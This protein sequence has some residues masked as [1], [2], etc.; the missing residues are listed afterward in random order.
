[1][2]IMI[3]ILYFNI[4]SLGIIS[5]KILNHKYFRVFRIH[6]ILIVFTIVQPILEFRRE[7]LGLV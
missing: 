6:I 4:I 3:S 5:I 7:E 1:M 2:M